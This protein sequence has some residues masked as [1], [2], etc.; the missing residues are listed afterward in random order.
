M[1]TIHPLTGHFKMDL[2]LGRKKRKIVYKCTMTQGLNAIL[3]EDCGAVQARGQMYKC[4]KSVGTPFPKHKLV[5]I[6]CGAVRMC[7]PKHTHG[8]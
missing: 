8:F 6:T 2:N 7:V 3:K 1:H 4:K 5:N